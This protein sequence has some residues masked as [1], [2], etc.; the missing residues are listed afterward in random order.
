MHELTFLHLT[1]IIGRNLDI[2]LRWKNAVLQMLSK[3]TPRF[4][5]DD[6]EFTEQPS[7]IRQ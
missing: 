7:S 2:F 6:E 5:A 1:E 4:L 3:S